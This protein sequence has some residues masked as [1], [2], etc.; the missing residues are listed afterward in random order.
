MGLPTAIVNGFGRWR[1]VTS[2][3]GGSSVAFTVV[4]TVSTVRHTGVQVRSR[5]KSVKSKLGRGYG[6]FDVAHGVRTV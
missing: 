1:S 6:K 3:R 2:L 4:G 5:T